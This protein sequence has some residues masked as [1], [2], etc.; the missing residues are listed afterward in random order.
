MHVFACTLVYHFYYLYRLLKSRAEGKSFDGNKKG[1]G[2]QKKK[3]KTRRIKPRARA[4]ASV[5]ANDARNLPHGEVSSQHRTSAPPAFPA[6]EISS[7][8]I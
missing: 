4:C 7:A 3:K 5:C 6:V 1:Q 2:R 8:G